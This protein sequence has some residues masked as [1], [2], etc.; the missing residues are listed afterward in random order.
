[1]VALMYDALPD[2]E[3]RSGFCCEAGHRPAEESSQRST[4]KQLEIIEAGRCQDPTPRGSTSNPVKLES[5]LHP[6]GF[7]HY[8]SVVFLTEVSVP[9]GIPLS[10]TEAPGTRPRGDVDTSVCLHDQTFVP[11]SLLMQ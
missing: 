10:G 5:K 3:A 6:P 9:V 2:N 11:V 8:I 7:Y 4:A 1:M